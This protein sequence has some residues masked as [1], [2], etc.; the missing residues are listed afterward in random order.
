MKK[1]DLRIRKTKA[2]LY[3]SLLQLMED[4]PF[5]EI[6]VSRICQLSMINRSTFYDHFNDKYEL[7]SS[8]IQ[9]LK[10]ELVIHLNH[11]KATSSIKEY[12]LELIRLLFEY[13]EKNS[14]VYTSISIIKMNDHSIAYDMM[15]DATLEAVKKKMVEEYTNLSDIPIDTISLF[16]VSG[17]TKVLIDFL[18]KQPDMDKEVVIKYIADLLPEINYLVPKTEKK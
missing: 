7:L 16:Y 6:K 17:V 11:A 5:E 4:T 10:N 9:D 13:I 8:F 14:N 2:S 15:F 18:E 12:Y 1:E 3:K